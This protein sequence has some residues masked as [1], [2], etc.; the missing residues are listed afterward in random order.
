[1]TTITMDGA[2]WLTPDDFYAALLPALGAPDW[3]GHNLDA[4]EESIR[5]GDINRVNPPFAV[6]ITGLE[7]MDAKAR[8]IVYRFTEVIHDLATA[9]VSVSVEV[10]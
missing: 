2:A 6:R 1:M 3:H 5:D 10:G 8:A 4:L 9:G 7:T